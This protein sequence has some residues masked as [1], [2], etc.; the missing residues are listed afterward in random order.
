MYRGVPII[1]PDFVPPSSVPSDLTQAE[2]G[3][4][5]GHLLALDAQEHVGRLEVAVHEAVGVGVGHA[6]EDAVGEVVDLRLAEGA[7]G[8]QVLERGAGG[9]T[10][11]RAPPRRAA[12]ARR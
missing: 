2:V 11:A 5:G 4:L 8:E 9:R 3:D 1:T 7:A 12:R 6:A 10:R